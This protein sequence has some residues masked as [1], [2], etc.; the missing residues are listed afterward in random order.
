MSRQVESARKKMYYISDA[1]A[2][3]AHVK[4]DKGNPVKRFKHWKRSRIYFIKQY[5][6]D[7]W[8]GKQIA[9]LSMRMYVLAFTIVYRLK[10]IRTKRNDR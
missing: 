3:H 4:S 8:V 10:R 5:S 2:V 7:S 9:C 6:G 1:Q